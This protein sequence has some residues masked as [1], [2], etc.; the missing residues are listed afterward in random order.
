MTDFGPF[1]VAIAFWIFCGVC[2]VAGIIGDY[3]KR[4]A[5]LEPLRAA[6]EKGQQLDPAV[7][8]KLIATR[9]QGINPMGLMI[10]GIV[11]IAAGVGVGLFA[12]FLSHIAP[13]AFWPV[14]GGGMLAVCVGVGLVIAARAVEQHVRRQGKSGSEV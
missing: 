6:I 11:A 10:G 14:F 2:A 8:E 3:K 5:T 12:F 13:V 1:S 7:V 4:Q 9:E